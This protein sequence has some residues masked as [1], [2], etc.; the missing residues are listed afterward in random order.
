MVEL[1]RGYDVGGRGL[2][3]ILD[4]SEMAP[5]KQGERAGILVAA[6]LDHFPVALLHRCQVNSGV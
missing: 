1:P 6:A 4:G 3:N 2:R 5:L